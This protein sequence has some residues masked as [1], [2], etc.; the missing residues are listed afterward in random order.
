MLAGMLRTMHTK[1]LRGY[2]DALPRGEMGKFAAEL[3]ISPVYL[4]QLASRQDGREPS[5]E[6]CVRIEQATDG[7]VP[8]QLLRQDWPR[9]W[10]ELTEQEA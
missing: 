1:T 8:R 6:L 10:P 3:A 9:I 7:E 2:L 4:S 5:P